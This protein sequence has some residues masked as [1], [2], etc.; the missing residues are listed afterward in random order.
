M[1][2]AN[3]PNTGRYFRSDLQGLRAIAIALVV[4][5]H[6]DIPGFAGGFVGVDVF[7]VLSG[8][9]I[10]GLLLRE[11]LRT[12]GIR[13]ARFLARRLRRLLPAMLAM[14]CIVLGVAAMLLSA[15]ELRMQTGSFA[16]S[17]TWTSNFFFAF[18]E[19]DYFSAL[20]VK[21]LYLHTWSLGIEEQFYVV[22]PWLIVIGCSVS[23]ANTESD[24]IRRR[25][26]WMFGLAFVAGFALC[27]FWASRTPLLGFYMMPSRA[28]QFA[29]G[30]MV[31]VGLREYSAAASARPRRI[32]GRW[33][34]LL[35]GFG[36]V[37]ILSSAVLLSPT[38]TYPGYHALPPSL[39]AT[40]MILGGSF[41][42]ANK[43]NRALSSA[44]FVW[45]GDRSYSLYLWHWPILTLGGAYGITDKLPGTAV[46]VLLAVLVAAAS[47]RFVELPFWKGRLSN[48]APASTITV[49]GL[50]IVIAV[51]A[52]VGV[53]AYRT[54]PKT[55]AQVSDS[56][57]PRTDAPPIYTA[58]FSCD[59]G[60]LSAELEPCGLGD[61]NAAHT[62]VLIGD[63]IGAQWVSLLPEIYSGPDWQ[64]L[65]FT[66]SAC[67]I[68]DEDY[69]YAKVGGIY[70]VCTDWRNAVLDRVRNLRPDVVFVG[71]SA[72]Y[73]FSASQ[74]V[75]GTRRVLDRLSG[76]ARQ[77]AV[78]AGTPSLSF[79]GPS[80]LE[81]PYRYSFRL[82][83]SRRECEEALRATR[84]RDVARYLQAA[85]EGMANVHLLD[86]N[87]LVCPDGR[88]SASTIDGQ[89]VFR[90]EQHLTDSFVVAQVP[91][92]QERLSALRL[93]PAQL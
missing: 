2:L 37:L 58:G 16:Y 18:H 60:H 61:P 51:A 25:L 49:A 17:A 38:L 67:A 8:Y 4:L 62:A 71:T 43:V 5:A 36:F 70:Q 55:F 75:H 65:V 45:L 29:L 3:D 89:A 79:D 72:G 40:L 82:G 30:A 24:S 87:D 41:S 50:S 90:D 34:G 57:D 80:C 14:L 63:S 92:I 47:Y 59:T 22:W 9:L 88:C 66:K 48:F 10:T 28:W 84:S 32:D 54:A 26:I 7:F 81:E 78:V 68:V 20:A 15:Y 13:Y 93:T 42:R 91:A 56:Y 21:D 31:F 52:S 6:A 27:L 19:F 35:T 11:R 74:W 83:D 39:G 86:L 12:G 53:A 1:R 76:H 23:A 33:P 85:M 46:L 69:Y 44:P 77:V 73:S 64:I